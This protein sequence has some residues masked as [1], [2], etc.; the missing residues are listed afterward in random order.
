MRYDVALGSHRRTVDAINSPRPL[1]ERLKAAVARA[2]RSHE[3]FTVDGTLREG[4][5]SQKSVRRK[6]DPSPPPSDG[7]QRAPSVAG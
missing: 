1:C 2:V 4:C 5:A 3:H 7:D 6:V